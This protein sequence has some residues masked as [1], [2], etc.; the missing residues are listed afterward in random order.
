MLIG[1]DVGFYEETLISTHT[2][3]VLDNG[4]TITQNVT[5]A[6][7]KET[8]GSLHASRIA[9]HG[10]SGRLAVRKH[11]CCL[12]VCTLYYNPDE[13]TRTSPSSANCCTGP[14]HCT[15]LLCGGFFGVLLAALRPQY[16]YYTYRHTGIA[17][18]CSQ[19]LRLRCREAW[20]YA[21]RESGSAVKSRLLVGVYLYFPNTPPLSRGL[22]GHV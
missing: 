8:Q 5:V 18:Y 17:L 2:A 3:N 21:R 10:I 1:R 14:V 6:E 13:R 11:N 4:D 9:L 19:P 16:V 20:T 15:Y 22:H 12:C 7:C